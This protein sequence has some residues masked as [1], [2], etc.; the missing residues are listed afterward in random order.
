MISVA[1]QDSAVEQIK[2]NIAIVIEKKK[3][4]IKFIAIN[5]K[6]PWIFRLRILMGA[7]FGLFRGFFSSVATITLRHAA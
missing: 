5:P 4:V 3:I 6:N 1:N 2:S 7:E